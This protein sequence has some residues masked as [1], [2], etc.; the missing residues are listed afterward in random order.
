[1]DFLALRQEGRSHGYQEEGFSPSVRRAISAHEVWTSKIKR[2]LRFETNLNIALL[3]EGERVSLLVYNH[4]PPDGGPSLA[5]G[6]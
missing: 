5:A 1:M 3:R 4:I 6:L 2:S